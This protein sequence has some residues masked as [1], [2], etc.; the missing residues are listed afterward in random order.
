MPKRKYEKSG[1]KCLHCDKPLRKFRTSI[2][3]DHRTLH[4]KC[5]EDRKR[6][7]DFNRIL[8]FDHIIKLY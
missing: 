5:Y 1:E 3:W 6:Y 7:L 2:D 4:K 8:K